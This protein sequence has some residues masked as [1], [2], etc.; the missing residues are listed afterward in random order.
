MKIIQ[1]Y[2]NL[3]LHLFAKLMNNTGKVVDN[4]LCLLC[5]LCIAACPHKCIYIKDRKIKV[6]N[7]KC[8]DCG[9]CQHYCPGMHSN[10]NI[11]N[12][13]KERM[14]G[15]ALESYVGRSRNLNVIKKSV[16]GGIV[17][18]IISTLLEMNLYELAIGVKDRQLDTDCVM[19]IYDKT[20][21]LNYQK[22]IYTMP[23]YTDVIRYIRDHKDK[24]IIIVGSGCI[25]SSIKK[26]V[27]E[28]HLNMDNYLF[29]GLFCDCTLS[30]N[31][32]LYFKNFGRGTGDSIIGLD[33]RCKGDLKKWPGDVR[34]KYKKGSIFVPNTERQ[35][36]VKYFRNERCLYCLDHMNTNAD[37]SVGD[38]YT[39]QHSDKLGSNSIV[40]RSELGRKIIRL[41]GPNIHIYEVPYKDILNSQNIKDK[42]DNYF[43]SKIIEEQKGISINEI[44]IDDMENENERKILKDYSL[45]LKRIGI[46]KRYRF[47]Q[48]FWDMYLMTQNKD[49]I[50]NRVRIIIKRKG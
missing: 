43:Y 9:L 31:I 48:L 5:G 37:I 11:G 12:S 21:A 7:E 40:I 27:R 50:R 30:P 41:I 46:G 19:E 29:V 24:K 4:G 23:L 44:E 26:Y 33:Y 22:S 1:K 10:N 6:D 25:V 38:N 32:E 28:T 49:S 35:K 17:T 15:I 18:E 3:K 34:L 13:I 47:S 42:Y 39:K 16:S 2:S 20:A 8:T 36:V 45:K 14:E